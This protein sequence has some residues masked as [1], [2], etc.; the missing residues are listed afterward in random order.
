MSNITVTHAESGL[1]RVQVLRR[2]QVT[3]H[4]T[5]V[6]FGGADLRRFEYRGFDQWF[7]LALPIR[8][9]LGLDR[10]PDRFGMR[11]YL[12]YLTVPKGMRPVV[13]NYTVRDFRAAGP[14]LDVDFLVHGSD[15]VAGPWAQRAEPGDE[16]ALIDQGCG[17]KPVPARWHLIAADESGLP[18]VA[19]ILRDLPREATGH[20]LIELFD[21]RDAQAMEPPPGFTVHWLVREPE[22]AP[23]SSL[24]PALA[25]L[26]FPPGDPYAFAVG[27][28]ALA[29]G[30]RRYL[31]RERGIDKGRVTFCGYWKLSAPART[32]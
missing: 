10:M 23:G 11:G 8:D 19:G 22:A 12:R 20:A 25:A 18:A 32:R 16:A 3:P 7:R 1:L 13:R 2:Q 21:E 31:V 4:M 6:T 30:V 15:G 26:Q 29:T 27:E 14:E 24:L 28:S 17:W 9:D 5:R